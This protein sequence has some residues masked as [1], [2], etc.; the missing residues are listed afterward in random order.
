[1]NALEVVKN[2]YNFVEEKN[3][4]A[5]FALLSPH[6]ECY[7]TEELP[8]GGSYQ[9][10]DGIKAFLSKLFSRIES[11]VD[12]AHYI[13]AGDKIVAVG[14]TSGTAKHTGKPFRCDLVHI[15]TVRDGKIARFEVYI[16]TAKMQVALA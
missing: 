10:L 3:T 9:G 6:V 16:D 8:W 13:E 2:V 15:W 7:Q 1:M 14:T 4:H 11:S 12:I 5:Y